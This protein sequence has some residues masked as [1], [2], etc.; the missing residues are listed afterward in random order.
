MNSFL[1]QNKQNKW[2]WSYH[3][4]IRDSC[5]KIDMHKSDIVDFVEIHDDIIMYINDTLNWIPSKNP[6]DEFYQYS[7]AG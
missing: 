5:G 4:V 7:A 6:A 3:N 1:F 2:N